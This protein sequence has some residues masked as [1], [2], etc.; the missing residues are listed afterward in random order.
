MLLM[1]SITEDFDSR[2]LYNMEAQIFPD[3]LNSSLDTMTLN[4][5]EE[6]KRLLKIIVL[7]MFFIISMINVVNVIHVFSETKSRKIARRSRTVSNVPSADDSHIILKNRNVE[8]G[9]FAYE[10]RKKDMLTP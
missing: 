7:V 3:E 1:M 5:L 2:N 9:D 8:I 4:E 10:V 6:I